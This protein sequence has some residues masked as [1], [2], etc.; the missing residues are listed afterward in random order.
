MNIEE[1]KEMIRSR[2]QERGL[3]NVGEEEIESAAA[4]VSKLHSQMNEK[5]SNDLSRLFDFEFQ[6]APFSQILDITG[7]DESSLIL[8]LGANLGQ[9]LDEIIKLGAEVHAFEPHPLLGEFL[10][11]KYQDHPNVIVNQAAAGIKKGEVKFYY[12]GSEKEINGG[13]SLVI[14]KMRGDGVGTWVESTDIAD[15]IVRLDRRV[16]ILKVD[17][18]GFEYELL[19]HLLTT[20]AIE[21][22]DYILF[23]DH[24]ECFSHLPWF[25]NALQ[26]LE[27][28][29][30]KNPSTKV[31][32]WYGTPDIEPLN[33]A[34]IAELEEKSR[35]NK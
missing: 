15:Y 19:D 23:E 21:N 7:A 4:R 28:F 11:K 9:Q 20:E 8:D 12:K 27:K 29:E 13:V 1:F 6:R 5:L 32:M 30:N 25:E 17:I 2:L 31:Y 16:K 33:Q 18:E 35:E 22:I 34:L 3:T 24:A 10:E 14:W 26:A